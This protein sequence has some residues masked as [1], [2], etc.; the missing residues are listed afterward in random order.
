MAKRTTYFI[1]KYRAQ[2][3]EGLEYVEEEFLENNLP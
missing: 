1:E 2:L 3:E